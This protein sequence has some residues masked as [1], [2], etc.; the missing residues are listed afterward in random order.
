MIHD[1]LTAY[2]HTAVLKSYILSMMQLMSD[3]LISTFKSFIFF[4]LSTLP[5]TY[6]V[7]HT[8]ESHGTLP[9]AGITS[10]N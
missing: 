2:S 10:G 6:S 3:E 5:A 8:L 9:A 4:Q 7:H 1:K